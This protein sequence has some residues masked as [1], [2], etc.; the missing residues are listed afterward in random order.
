MRDPLPIRREVARLTPEQRRDRY[1]HLVQWAAR[2]Y[3]EAGVLPTLNR[4]SPTAYARLEQAAWDRY[5]GSLPEPALTDAWDRYRGS[6]PEPGVVARVP[7]HE[8]R[9]GD[10]ILVWWNPG[11]DTITRLTPYTGPL[12][13]VLGEGTLLADFALSPTGMTL[14]AGAWFERLA[15]GPGLA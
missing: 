12:L 8:L 7:T 6:P 15:K 1:L 5:L 10:T 14:E 3:T 13:A 11:R 2:R 9:V 4:G